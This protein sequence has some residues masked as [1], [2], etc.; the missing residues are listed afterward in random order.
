[1]ASIL[2]LNVAHALGG[3]GQ[4]NPKL[5]NM[6]TEESEGILEGNKQERV[7]PNMTAHISEP[8]TCEPTQQ[9]VTKHKTPEWT[10]QLSPNSNTDK[11]T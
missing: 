4:K 11:V 6:A 5:R 9:S 3:D 8:R 2:G 7:S 10:L 1:M